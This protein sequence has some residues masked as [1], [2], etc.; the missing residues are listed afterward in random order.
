M[1]AHALPPTT[2]V[3]LAA[4]ALLSVPRSARAQYSPDVPVGNGPR[5]LTPY[6][7][8]SDPVMPLTPFMTLRYPF[9]MTLVPRA[10]AVAPA[11]APRVTHPAQD[12]GPGLAALPPRRVMR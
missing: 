9:W 3:L 7:E 5:S 4:L 12:P 10:H 11:R 1:R 6:V 2:V 8:P